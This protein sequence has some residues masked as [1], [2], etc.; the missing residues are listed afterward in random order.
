MFCLFLFYIFSYIPPFSFFCMRSRANTQSLTYLVWCRGLLISC[1]SQLVIIFF[2]NLLPIF[3][4]SMAFPLVNGCPMCLV[5]I[6]LLFRSFEPVLFSRKRIF[7]YIALCVVVIQSV[8][9]LM[10]YDGILVECVV[11]SLTRV[12]RLSLFS[13]PI[14]ILYASKLHNGLGHR[15]IFCWLWT[16]HYFV[17]VGIS[18]SSYILLLECFIGSFPSNVPFSWWRSI[19]GLDAHYLCARSMYV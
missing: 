11:R 8:V 13:F 16:T 14:C 15:S 6:P 5:V 18:N 9:H 7:E 12:C 17:Y 4:K 10:L 2:V 19:V 1:D 3:V